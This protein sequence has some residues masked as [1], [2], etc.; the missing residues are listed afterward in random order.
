MST[1]V[2]APPLLEIK[3]L[4]IAYRT[5][6]GTV[7]AVD[8]V[9]LSIPH[10]RSIGL[11]G[12][13]GS[14]K[15]TI[16]LAAMRGCQRTRSQRA[17]HVQRHRPAAQSEAAPESGL[18]VEKHEHV[19]RNHSRPCARASI[20]MQM[21]DVLRTTNRTRHEGRKARIKEY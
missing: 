18:A 10:G 6:R 2:M 1:P 14:G 15:S 9:S 19:S 20:G 13:S 21:D 11:V 17:D 16:A 4:S 5:D 7:S 8:D 3:N 12:E